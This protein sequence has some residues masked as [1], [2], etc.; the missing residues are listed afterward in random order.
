MQVDEGRQALGL[1]VDFKTPLMYLKETQRA[2]NEM[3]ELVGE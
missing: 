3:I 2:L 1:K